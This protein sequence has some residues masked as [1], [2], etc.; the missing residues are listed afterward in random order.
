MSLK[1]E[2]MSTKVKQSLKFI[3]KKYGKTRIKE[4]SIENLDMGSSCDCIGG[5]LEGNYV[6]F[7]VKH[8]LSWSQKIAMGFTEDWPRYTFNQL[9]E[10]WK[11]QLSLIK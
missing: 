9:T 3:L 5:Q 1:L 6:N 7:I 2:E 11:R 4:I 10:E 8:N